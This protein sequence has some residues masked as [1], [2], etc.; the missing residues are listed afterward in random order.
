MRSLERRLARLEG[1]APEQD[2]GPELRSLSCHH[3]C[4]FRDL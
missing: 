2:V 1:E 3:R 4:L